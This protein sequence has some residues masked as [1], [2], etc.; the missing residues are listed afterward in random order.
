MG[1]CR[2]GERSLDGDWRDPRRQDPS[3]D[4]GTPTKGLVDRDEAI[5]RRRFTALGNSPRPFC[6]LISF[7]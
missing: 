4:D 3:E 1:R 6:F 2:E 5:L 7:P